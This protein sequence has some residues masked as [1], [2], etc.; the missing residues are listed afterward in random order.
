[1]SIEFEGVQNVRDFGIDFAPGLLFRGGNLS[2]AT[3]ADSFKLASVLGVKTAIDLRCGWERAK[4]PDIDIPGARNI[5]IPLYDL[6]KVGI[7]YTRPAPGTI[8]IGRDVACE[9]SHYYKSLANPKTSRQIASAVKLAL[10]EACAGNPVY[11]HCSG[12]KDRAGIVSALILRTLGAD[13]A[14][15]AGDYELTNIS[16]D[17][18]LQEP[19]RK[20]LRFAQGDMK[21][22]IELCESHRANAINL[23]YFAE[24]AIELYGSM[25]VYCKDVLG[26][27]SA[28]VKGIRARLA[29]IADELE[30]TTNLEL[31][32]VA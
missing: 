11:I 7:E 32:G 23:D 13:S 15:I 2:M 22:A 8:R 14:S 16:R 26:L 12:G 19:L 3:Q 10:E 29:V 6:E 31:A 30:R 18:S 27:D 21:L 20:F 1:M 9:P 28:Y 5:H 24:G 25:D 4:H 17:M